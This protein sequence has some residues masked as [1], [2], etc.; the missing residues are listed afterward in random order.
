MLKL[1]AV[2]IA[3]GSLY[4]QQV[5]ELTLEQKEAFLKTAKVKKA[6]GAK[7]GVTGTNQATLSDGTLTHDAS[8]Q[9]IDDTKAKF[10]TAQG[11]EYNFQDSYKLNIAAYRIAQLLGMGEMVPVSVERLYSGKP[12]SYTWWIDNVQMDE[13]ERLR[14]KIQA[15]DKDRWSRQYLLM[16]VFDQLIY[17]VDRNATNIVYDKDWKL[18]MIDHSRAFRRHTKLPDPKALDRCDAV[19][20]ARLKELNESL[21][22]EKVG[23]WLDTGQIRTLLARRNLIVAHFE[24]AGSTKQYDFLG[25]RP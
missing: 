13:V 21:L 1:A 19:L 10:E 14:K 3:L 4:A 6:V 23:R 5:P 9:T 20:L 24:A 7:K 22:Q 11:T 8:I 15:P 25:A 16:R 2:G 12:G 18:W 17:N